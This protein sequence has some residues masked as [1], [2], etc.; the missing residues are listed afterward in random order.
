MAPI[1][2]HFELVRMVRD[3]SSGSIFY[4]DGN[5][6]PDRS[7]GGIEEWLISKIKMYLVFGSGISGEAAC[8]LLF[9]KKEQRSYCMMVTI[10]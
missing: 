1:H 5:P 8:E 10:N 4:C 3:K 7:Y 9:D 6:L 2:H